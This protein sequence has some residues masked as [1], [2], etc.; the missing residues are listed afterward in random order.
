MMS[1]L[2]ERGYAPVGT[3]AECRRLILDGVD[4]TTWNTEDYPFGRE[5]FAAA[6]HFETDE[7]VMPA[8][9]EAKTR[10]VAYARNAGIRLAFKRRDKEFHLSTEKLAMAQELHLLRALDKGYVW[11]T[12]YSEADI[13]TF[14]FCFIGLAAIA[15]FDWQEDGSIKQEDLVGPLMPGQKRTQP[16]ALKR[17]VWSNGIPKNWDEWRGY[18]VAMFGMILQRLE[19]V[20]VIKY[21]T[22]G[23]FRTLTEREYEMTTDN[24]FERVPIRWLN[25]HPFVEYR[26]E[27]GFPDYKKDEILVSLGMP[28]CDKLQYGDKY[29]LIGTEQP[30]DFSG[31]LI[32]A[33]RAA[34]LH[35]MEA[36]IK[37]PK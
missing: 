18:E 22:Y 31:F 5:I 14:T 29:G 23:M 34:G 6:R 24:M 10:R 30:W 35:A 36:A 25:P 3:R 26:M 4:L 16:R 33:E 37:Q 28:M 21:G 7:W 2:E 17:T 13:Q 8:I 32:M 11:T 1:H 19:E 27:A 15:Y 20:G 9:A 12:G